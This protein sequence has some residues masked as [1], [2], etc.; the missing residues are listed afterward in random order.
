LISF[1]T[2]SGGKLIISEFLER[3]TESYPINLFY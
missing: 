2:A 3:S 1:F